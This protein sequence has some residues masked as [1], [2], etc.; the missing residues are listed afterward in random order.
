MLSF[1]FTSVLQIMNFIILMVLLTKYLYKP[2][3]NM[4]DERKNKIASDLSKAEE[5]RKN[6]EVYREEMRKE[7]ER[8]REEARRIIESAA[9]RAKRFEEEQKNKAK[10]EAVKMIDDAKREIEKEREK[11]F[12][13]VRSEAVSIAILLVKR[14][15]GEQIDIEVKRRYLEDVMKE[16]NK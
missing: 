10:L 4:M 8:A 3:L 12:Q 2:F 11:A 9:E 14:I 16:L 15:L 7:L 5:F 13:S 6:A 1:N